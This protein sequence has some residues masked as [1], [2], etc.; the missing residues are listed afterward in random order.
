MNY[1]G[2]CQTAPPQFSLNLSFI[3]YWWEINQCLKLVQSGV[4]NR[5]YNEENGHCYITWPLHPYNRF[6]WHVSQEMHYIEFLL[7][8]L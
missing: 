8:N 1:K 6:C 2:K 4:T 7:S 3:L 5:E